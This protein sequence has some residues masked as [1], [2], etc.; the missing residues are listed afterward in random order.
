MWLLRNDVDV[1][2]TSVVEVPYANLPCV[3]AE[4]VAGC[5]RRMSQLDATRRCH[6][7]MSLQAVTYGCRSKMSQELVTTFKHGSIAVRGYSKMSQSV[8]AV[9]HNKMS[10]RMS[11]Q[12]V[13]AVSHSSMS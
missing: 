13:V 3:A 9:S 7:K 1:D 8:K 5:Y 6:S 10:G 11:R 12:E 2:E 4:C